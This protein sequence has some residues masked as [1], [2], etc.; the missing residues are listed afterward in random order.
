M[1]NPTVGKE[2]LSYCTSC[3]MDLAHT[4]S[5]MVG[6]RIARVMCRTCKK[7]HVYRAPK[8][9][10]EPLP[11]TAKAPAGPKAPKA[12]PIEEEW[13]K[14]MAE[15]S[16]LQEKAYGTKTHFAVGEKISHPSF[17]KGIVMKHVY[18]NKIEVIFQSD[19]K[20]LIHAGS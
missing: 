4:I 11:K 16:S 19:M 9:I 12:T 3:R 7:E 2:T 6:E 18:P 8:G 20:V 5:V 13:E 1:E 14:L 17:G 15:K 10:N